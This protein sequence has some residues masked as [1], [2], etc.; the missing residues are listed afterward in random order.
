MTRADPFAWARSPCALRSRAAPNDKRRSP[1]TPPPARSS[2]R[3][4]PNAFP[5]F[6]ASGRPPIRPQAGGTAGR[7]RA[8]TAAAAAG[9][10][11]D[12]LRDSAMRVRPSSKRRSSVSVLSSSLAADGKPSSDAQVRAQP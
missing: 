3:S 8:A 4:P 5:T 12:L 2:P 9:S 11:A 10:S 1:W 6:R 7:Q